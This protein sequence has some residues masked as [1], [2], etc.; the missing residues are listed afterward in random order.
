MVLGGWAGLARASVSCALVV[1]D[2][3]EDSDMSV[4]DTPLIRGHLPSTSRGSQSCQISHVGLNG[5]SS[6]GFN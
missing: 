3:T 5:F 4:Y 2:T 1:A 6:Y